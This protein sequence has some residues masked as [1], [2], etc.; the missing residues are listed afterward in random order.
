MARRSYRMQAMEESLRDYPAIVAMHEEQTEKAE[1]ERDRWRETAREMESAR[2]ALY[3]ESERLRQVAN[4]A[5]ETVISVIVMLAGLTEPYDRL[6]YAE[7]CAIAENELR[8]LDD[9][10]AATPRKEQS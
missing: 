8:A 2:N 7:R 9:R 6:D 10:L 5:S 1:A 3:E 4:D